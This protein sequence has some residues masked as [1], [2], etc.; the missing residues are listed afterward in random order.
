M[1]PVRCLSVLLCASAGMASSSG[2]L[3]GIDY[4]EWM[5]PNAG[6]IAV[7]NSGAL[8]VLSSCANATGS[9][10]CV[11]KLSS[12][13]KT[14]MWSKY[15]GFAAGAMAVDPS[16]GVYVMAAAP[17][18]DSSA[19]F[20]E[21]LASNGAGAVWQTPIGFKLPALGGHYSLAVDATGRAFAAGYDP[22]A[23]GYVV[24]LN[25]AGAVDYTAAI[26]GVPRAIGVDSAGAHAVVAVAQGGPAFELAWI[27]PDLRT[28][29]YSAVTEIGNN[30]SLAVTP[31]GDALVYGRDSGGQWMLQRIAAPGTVK[32][33]AA[34]P[35]VD[36]G[37][38]AVDGAGNAYIT[39]NLGSVERSVKN[40]LMPCGSAWLSV[41]GPDG[42]QLQ[43]TYLPGASAAYPSALS[44]TTNGTGTFIAMTSADPGFVPS[45]TGPFAATQGS[46]AVLLHLSPNTNAQSVALA[47]IGN[48]ANYSTG[49]VAP[50]E[51]VTLFGTGLGPA[52]GVQTSATLD[53]QFPTQAASTE[54]TFDGRPA[55]LLWVQDGQI[56]AAVPWSVA[57]PMTQICVSYN[58]VKTNCLSWPVAQTAPG[59]F[60]LDGTY[61][62]AL[63]QDGTINT[64]TNPAQPGTIVAIFAT[65]LGP[66]APAPTDGAIVG[67]PL[68]SNTLPVYVVP[69]CVSIFCPANAGPPL[70]MPYSGPAPFLIAGAS[71]VNFRV[72]ASGVLH[73]TT[74][75][76]GAAPSSNNF[77]IYVA[78][79]GVQ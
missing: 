45:Q 47:C 42:A 14:V 35:A 12:T 43:T 48:A 27:A 68:P 38:L 55:P 13:G 44:V 70:E 2:F 59:V 40:S 23:G 78:D 3:L 24:R 66:I 51:L 6:A 15:L 52:Q 26:H 36:S 7:D 60:T 9:D 56:N 11:T 39:G 16:G 32:F 69:A 58:N 77:Q 41:I 49:P 34:V 18:S 46:P 57:G 50:G 71:Q 8:Y 63:N 72:T 54:V 79:Q 10:W 37:S 62:A 5:T 75:T 64:A 67:L 4:S 76:S 17:A 53:T 33:S 61:A 28:A 29:T 65:G 22:A 21:K 20:I 74:S 1:F 30:L 19:V 31:D 25:A 73:L